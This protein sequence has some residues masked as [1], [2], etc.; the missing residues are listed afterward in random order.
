MEKIII[1]GAGG[2][3]K[4]IHF[5]L[6]T[7]NQLKPTYDIVGF[8]D[9]NESKG[10]I[11]NDKPVLGGLSA[12]DSFK[13]KIN[14]V[15]S[16]SNTVIVKKLYESIRNPNVKYPNII[17]PSANVDEKYTKMG[18]GNVFNIGCVVSRNAEMG[19]FNSF[20]N[21]AAIGHDV[22]L[23][24]FNHFGPNVQI[25]G[26]VKIG[27]HNSWGLNSAIIQ[28]KNVGSGNTIGA[29]SLLIKNLSDDNSVFGIPAT[30]SKF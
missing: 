22:S 9:D 26:G 28:Y 23:G 16:M 4:D 21:G 14:I 2:F 20:N 27:D 5:M 10:S 1:Y 8:I 15:F 24:S 7:I 25:S 11:I 12:I 29:Y 3:G 6:D 19:N 18:I 13:E 30:I 17:H